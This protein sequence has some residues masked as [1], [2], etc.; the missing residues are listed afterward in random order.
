M[1]K[2]WNL[3]SVKRKI[4]TATWDCIVVGSGI[5]GLTTAAILAR[6]GMKVLVVESHD[7]PG[8]CL[9][10]FKEKG[11]TFHTGN[12]YIG[13][14]DEDM[15]ATWNFITGGKALIKPSGSKVVENFF[16]PKHIEKNAHGYQN[17]QYMLLKGEHMWFHTMRVWPQD[18]ISMADRL[19]WY[20][21]FK[22]LPYFIAYFLWLVFWCIYP[23]T[24]KTY[25]EWMTSKSQVEF[26]EGPWTMQEGDH[27]V[28][29]NDCLAMIGAAVA[30]HYMEGTIKFPKN[31]VREICKTI[32]SAKG[33]I[34]VCAKVDSIVCSQGHAAGIVLEDKTLIRSH[35]VVSAVGVYNTLSMVNLQQLEN[36][37]KKLSVSHFS[38]FIGLKGSKKTL[39]LPQGNA[40][41]RSK[42]K[43]DIFIS[44]D[45]Q[46]VKGET[47]TAVHILSPETNPGKW[48][49]MQHGTTYE[50]A[51][52]DKM[53]I[54]KNVFYELYPE[55]FRSEIAAIAGTPY[56]S[57]T[58]LNS[59]LGCSYGL[60]CGSERFT[61]WSNV[62]ALR[63]ETTVRGLYLTGQDIL[64]VG[65]CSALATG[66]MTARQI[67][68]YTIFSAIFK[69]DILDEIKDF[70]KK[71]LCDNK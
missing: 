5:S 50:A 29:R 68:G 56:T 39:N 49:Q 14:L 27:G 37:Y 47:V 58:Y 25:D 23:D 24:S 69:K 1:Y 55:T 26:V 18:V 40:W 4:S 32:K 53:N 20:V 54:L 45:E 11:I 57:S 7:R 71:H 17:T 12:H 48:F 44:F 60:K 62:R 34:L 70:N 19:K 64:M 43:N 63:P 13:V 22:L 3:N 10:T 51:K 9:H 33:E 16:Q 6:R 66:L 31:A 52:I 30:R 15:T 36:C 67:L 28:E 2:K 46:E 21:Y 59:P 35:R 41:I 38:V 8:G 42:D 61:K 65:I